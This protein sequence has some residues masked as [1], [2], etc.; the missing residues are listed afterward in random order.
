VE[1]S[2]GRV[3]HV[4][5]QTPSSV[6]VVELGGSQVVYQAAEFV[7]LSPKT[8]STGFRVSAVFGIDYKHQAASTTD[9]PAKMK[10]H[11]AQGLADVLDTD[12]V[13][14]V[15]VEFKEAAASSLDYQVDVDVRG[16]AAPKHL[17]LQRSISRLLVDA[18]NEN[19]WEIP[20]TQVTVHQA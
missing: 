14:N 8:L 5:Y 3:G 2:D 18:C 6:Q 19:G 9:I 11:L 15:N 7:G 17:V 1:L 20:F 10:S 12:L 4:A 16:E 13:R